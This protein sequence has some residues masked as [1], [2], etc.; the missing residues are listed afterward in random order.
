MHTSLKTAIDPEGMSF[1]YI[2]LNEHLGPVLESDEIEGW[3]SST[4]QCGRYEPPPTKYKMTEAMTEAVCKQRV[5]PNSEE[6]RANVS[7]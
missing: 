7:E 5:F 1:Q 2:R 6:E 4:K 3:L